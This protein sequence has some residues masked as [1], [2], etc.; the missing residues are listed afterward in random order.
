MV[1]KFDIALNDDRVQTNIAI[2]KPL[3]KVHISSHFAKLFDSVSKGD[4]NKGIERVN[5]NVIH[6]GQTQYTNQ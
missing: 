1:I 4:G 3:Y 6:C 2:K 5:G